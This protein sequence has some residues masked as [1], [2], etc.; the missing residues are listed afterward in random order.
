MN[1]QK[2]II[3]RTETRLDNADKTELRKKEEI[4]KP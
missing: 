3:L 1:S 2:Y 4:Y